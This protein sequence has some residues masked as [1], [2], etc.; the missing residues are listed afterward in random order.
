MA[1]PLL[2]LA[3][4]AACL[5]APQPAL[6]SPEAASDSLRVVYESGLTWEAFYAGADARRALWERNWTEGSAAPEVIARAR[7]TGG[8]WRLLVIT[9]PGCSDSVNTV[10]YIARLAEAVP[11]LD[12]RLV[13]STVGR[14]WMEAHR[15]PDGRA[16]TPTVL[17][18]DS[19]FEIRG[20]WVEQPKGLQGFWLDVVARGTASR[21]VGR[22]MAWYEEEAGRET[23][24]EI[25]EVMEAAQDGGIICPG[26]SS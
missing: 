5:S 3:L 6:S 4:P 20:C 15:S 7:A 9:E 8:P 16:S 11:A 14:P 22:K 18:L 23:L 10:P 13:N 2:L 17:L 25:V 26:I 19:D 21:E 12:L 24:T 1:H